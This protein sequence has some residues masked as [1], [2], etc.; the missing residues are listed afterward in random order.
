MKNKRRIIAAILLI[1]VFFSV[2]GFHIYTHTFSNFLVEDNSITNFYPKG[3]ANKYEDII[4]ESTNED[5]RV[6][7]YNLNKQES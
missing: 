2:L 3:V 4:V 7:K 1:L 5:H 6:W